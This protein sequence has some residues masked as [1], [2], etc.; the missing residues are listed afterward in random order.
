V[1]AYSNTPTITE[2]GYKESLPT[3]WFG[4]Y[5]PEG[6]PEEVRKTLVAA[7]ICD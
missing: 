7:I 2:L 1:P 4:L 6:I 3:A 5:A